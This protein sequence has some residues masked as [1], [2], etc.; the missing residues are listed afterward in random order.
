MKHSEATKASVR[1]KI[2]GR[3]LNLKIR[4]NG[5]GF[6]PD[7]ENPNRGLGLVGIGERAK[8][9][10]AEYEID[11]TEKGTTI[12]LQMNLPAQKNGK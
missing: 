6:A 3:V 5:K 1:L 11:S 9:L 8:I 7:S 2:N 4:D 10:D 12:K